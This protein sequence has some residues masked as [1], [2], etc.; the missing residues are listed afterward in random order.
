MEK[1]TVLVVAAIITR[2]D[3][4]LINQRPNGDALAGRW[5]F[6]GGKVEPGEDPRAAL[7]RECHEELGCKVEVGAAYETVFHETGQA[8]LLLLFYTTRVTTGEPQAM[9][10]NT[11]AWVRPDELPS[12]D[13][14][15]AD[16]PL[17]NLLQRKFPHFEPGA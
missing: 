15:E 12:Y 16:R 8:W 9:E 2:G 1:P 13:L 11:L 14:L 6:P 7:V 17:V 5:E 3:T 4:L 10:G